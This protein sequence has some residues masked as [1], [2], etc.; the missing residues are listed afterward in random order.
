LRAARELCTQR[1]ALLIFDEVQC[2]MGRLGPL[3]A[4]AHFGVQPDAV[5]LAKALAN[6]L[7]IGAMLVREKFAVG[8]QPGD[9]GSTFGGS[10]VPCAAALAHLR[11][12]DD[13]GLQERVR[14]TSIRLFDGLR[15]L[16]ALYP[17]VYG[18]PR[19]LGLLAGLPVGEPID[20][21][22]I[23]QRARE[24]SHVLFNKAGGNTVRMAPPLIAGDAEIDRA[25]CALEDAAA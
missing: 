1:G 2:G 15:N 7:P 22:T 16:A 20:A 12:R 8:L 21:G 18:E 9:H 23:V 3:F 4:F 25:I 14:R 5:T 17:N 10:P 19:G 11:V 13:T 6:G 24:R